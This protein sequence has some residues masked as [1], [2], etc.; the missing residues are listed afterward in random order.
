MIVFR[1]QE[2][3]GGWFVGNFEPSAFKTDDFEVCLKKHAKGEKWPTHYH[4]IATEINYLIKGT[5]T[6]QD[7]TFNKGDVFVIAPNEV[8]DPEFLE[9]CELIVIKTPFV[10]NDKFEV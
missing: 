6:I 2:W 5:M 10:R 3:K 7:T 8:A 1:N 4:K 9:D